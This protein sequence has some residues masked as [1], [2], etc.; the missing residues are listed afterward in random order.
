MSLVLNTATQVGNPGR[1]QLTYGYC[2]SAMLATASGASPSGC[3][4]PAGP[5][6]P[7]RPQGSAD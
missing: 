4:A 1:H 3:L 6:G 5:A 7:T 2:V